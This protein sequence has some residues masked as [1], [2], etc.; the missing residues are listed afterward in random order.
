MAIFH[1]GSTT[2]PI[3]RSAPFSQTMNLSAHGIK[4]GKIHNLIEWYHC[5]LFNLSFAEHLHFASQCSKNR[6]MKR[7]Q[8][9]PSNFPINSMGWALEHTVGTRSLEEKDT[10]LFCLP[11]FLLDPPT[12]VATDVQSLRGSIRAEYT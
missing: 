9:F 4:K 11:N 8:F 5:H 10:C 3:P 12:P 2:A 6:A 1:K 7:T